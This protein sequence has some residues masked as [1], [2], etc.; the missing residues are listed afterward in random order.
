MIQPIIV[1]KCE[2]GFEIVAGERRW[3]AGRKAGLKEIPCIIRELTDEENM[4]VAIIEN[5]QREDL[6]PVEEAQAMAQMMDTYGLTQE[7]V[8]KTLGKSRPYIANSLRLLKLPAEI[9]ELLNVSSI[10]AGQSPCCCGKQ[11]GSNSFG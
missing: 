2:N 5:T 11:G 10:S 9:Q 1:R 6:S 8:G 3:R 7:Q 4:L